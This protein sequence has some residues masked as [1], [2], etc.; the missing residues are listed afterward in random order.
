[1]RKLIKILHS[2]G[3][4]GLAGGLATFM[5]VL[6]A[7]PEMSDIGAYASLRAS[8]DA[9]SSTIIVPSLGLTIVSGVMALA[10]HYPFTEAPWVWVKALSG[11]PL[12]EATLALVDAPARDAAAASALAAAGEM[13]LSEL[14]LAVE[15]NWP[16]WSVLMALCAINVI[17]GVWRPLFGRNKER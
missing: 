8:L 13:D 17:F 5:V 11:L 1:M 16:G 2:V 12:F 14:A 4:I 6:A 10:V 9:V 3:A 15:D 7:G